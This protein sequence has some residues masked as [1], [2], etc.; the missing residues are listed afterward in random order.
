[1]L[2]VCMYVRMYVCTDV[3][4]LSTSKGKPLLSNENAM[5][6]FRQTW[7]VGSGGHKYYYIDETWY[8]GSDGHKYY[9]I[10]ETWYVGSDGHKYY[11][12][13]LSSPDTH[14]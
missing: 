5:I 11:P 1:M 12:C 6:D 13:G 7:Y 4:F 8:V 10:D 14:I 3:G 9:Y 2:S